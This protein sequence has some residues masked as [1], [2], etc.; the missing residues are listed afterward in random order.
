M[1]NRNHDED[2]FLPDEELG[3]IDF[4]DLNDDWAYDTVD[5]DWVEEDFEDDD[6]DDELN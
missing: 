6:W 3:D 2:Q 1:F 5:D 4:E